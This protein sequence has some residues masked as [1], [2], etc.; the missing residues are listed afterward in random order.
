[1]SGSLAQVFSC[2]FCE[3]SENNP[4]YGTP[5]VA[6]FGISRRSAMKWSKIEINRHKMWLE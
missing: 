4:S 2:E 6:A 5:T 1:M 3:I